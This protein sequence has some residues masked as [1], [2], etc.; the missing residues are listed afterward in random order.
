M[1]QHE[2]FDVYCYFL[3]LIACAMTLVGYLCWYNITKQLCWEKSRVMII[4]EWLRSIRIQKDN[5]QPSLSNAC[6]YIQ[7]VAKR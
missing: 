3:V 6:A 1:Y 5:M 2:E 7:T 4:N